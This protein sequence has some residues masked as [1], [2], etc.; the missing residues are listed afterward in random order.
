[1]RLVPGVELVS[2]RRSGARRGFAAAPPLLAALALSLSTFLAIGLVGAG[3]ASAANPTMSPFVPGKHVYNKGD[4]LSAK[5]ATTAEA[6]A[7]DI[8]ANG[9]G[10]VVVYADATDENVPDASSLAAAWHVDG[11]LLTGG[12]NFGDLLM[13]STLKGK[14]IKDQIDSIQTSQGPQTIESWIL[15]SLARVDAFLNGTHVFD[16]TGLLDAATRAKAESAA[17][18]LGSKIGAPVYIDIAL[19]DS[20]GSTAAFFNGADLSSSLRSSLIIALGVAD[21]SIGGFTQSDNSNLFDKYNDKSPWSGPTLKNET[22]PNGDVPAALMTA[23]NAVQRGSSSSSSSSG[24]GAGWGWDVWFWIVFAIVMVII[25][26]G[27]PFYGGWLVR[28]LTGTASIKGGVP[29]DA[30][31][32]G[33]S[34]TGVTV[35]GAGYGGMSPEY[36][37]TLQVTPAAGGATYQTEAKGIVP[38]IYIP[39]VVP[40]ARVGVL[41]DP[42][43][44][45]KVSIDFSRLGGSAPDAAAAGA[46]TTPAPGT[47]GPGGMNFQFDANGRPLDGEVSS[48]VGAVRSGSLPTINKGSAD[49]LLATGT[50]GTAVITACQP[51]GKTVRDINPKADPSRLDDPMWVF[52]VQ[53]S[54]A[55]E[56]PFPAVFGHRVPVAK[57]GSIAPGVKLAIAV[58]MSDRHNEVA[59]DWDKSPIGS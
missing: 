49:Q 46:A 35:S 50:H 28:K 42:T 51:M 57:V 20:D 33:I 55:G 7:A 47:F 21:G 54:V 31:I 19:A 26:V 53:V 32:E 13:G 6:L 17:K 23:I 12:T 10:R 9:G 34:D 38:R 16:G 45:M 4:V 8:E 52:T 37:F 40:G 27:S 11:M 58:D 44:P 2:L 14:L 15:T 18:A 3:P 22:A 5:S 1:M 56:N 41:I 36:K 29:G 59:I 48:L 30:V 25:G 43:N 39:M 24:S